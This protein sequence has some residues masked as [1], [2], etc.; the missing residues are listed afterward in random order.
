MINV[1]THPQ[2]PGWLPERLYPF[3]SNYANVDGSALHYVDEGAGPPLL[4]LH[5]NPTW[6]FVYRN[7]I[8]GLR[9]R[10]RCIAPDYPGFGLSRAATSYGYTPAEHA[11]AIEQLILRLDLHDLTMMV[12]DWGG[13]I[14]FAAATRQPDRFKAFVIGNSWAWPKTDLGTSVFSRVLSSPVGR[15]LILR[16]D[17]FVD[18]VIARSAR[19]QK[20]S[21][22]VLRAYRGPFPTAASREPVYVLPR[23]IRASRAFLADIEL[24][25][26]VLRDRAALIVWPTNDVLFRARERQRW[27]AIF[28]DHETINLEGAGHYIQEEA[29]EQIVAAARRWAA[30]ASVNGSGARR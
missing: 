25:L 7:I 15:Y 9:D 26:P 10:Y 20:I 18:T 24:R 14:G 2:R 8:D 19:R 16:R 1:I 27:E 5:G 11:H 13:P 22:D 17:G 4:L 21:E 30:T 3:Q 28:P 12:H 6:S 29:P 23:E